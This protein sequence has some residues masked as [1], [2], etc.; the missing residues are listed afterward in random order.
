MARASSS[1]GSISG[2]GTGLTFN[3][4]F[5]ANAASLN[6]SNSGGG[7]GGGSGTVGNGS[8]GQ[9]AYYPVTGNTVV[10]TTITSLPT[11]TG[12][13]TISSGTWNATAIGYQYGGTGLTALGSA[14][15]CL[16]TNSS[17]TGMV[18]ATCSGGSGTV[19]PGIAGQFAYYAT[20]GQAVSG[21][22]LGTG[23]ATAL[24][25]NTGTTGGF[26]SISGT[27]T[28]G[29]C[30][31]ATSGGQIV[32]AGGACTTGGGGGTV[33]PGTAGQLA[34]YATSSTTIS[35]T[36]TGAGVLTAIGVGVN[37]PGGLATSA[38]SSLTSLTSIGTITTG[39][40][41]ATPVTFA[42]G[43]TGLSALG[44]ANQCLTT[45]SSVTAMVWASCSGSSSGT[46]N[47]GTA[48]QLAYYATTGTAVSG[49][50]TDPSVIT[51]VSVAVNTS[52]GLATSAVTTLSSLTSIGSISSGC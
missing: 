32:D 5:G 13:G 50:A 21:T 19:N 2:S 30:L 11:L 6:G 7:G 48:G 31:S 42:F 45:N 25:N 15:Q 23:V 44:T 39:I 1:S 43:G 16:T 46:V 51:A 9:F 17:V 22:T 41:N 34:Y 4:Y 10:G 3:A 29:H 37:T 33:S 36:A 40:W 47:A 52:G 12:V 35:G 8:S 49:T 38:V 14:N 20:S 24:A 26:A 27:L 28:S 18:W